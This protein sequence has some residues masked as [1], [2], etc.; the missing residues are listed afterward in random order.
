MIAA[1]YEDGNDDASPRPKGS[2]AKAST[3]KLRE[4]QECEVL[5]RPAKVI[6][7]H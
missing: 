3:Q 1:G 5:Q 4:T 6:A 2:D 7:A